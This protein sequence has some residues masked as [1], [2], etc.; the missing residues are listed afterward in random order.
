MGVITSFVRGLSSPTSFPGAQAG[1]QRL[2]RADR[3]FRQAPRPLSLRQDRSIAQ[4]PP[5]P[6]W[7]GYATPRLLSTS[8][9]FGPPSIV[10]CPAPFARK[11]MSALP[12]PHLGQSGNREP[13]RAPEPDRQKQRHDEHCSWVEPC[14]HIAWHSIWVK[15]PRM[16]AGR[17]QRSGTIMALH[18]RS[19]AGPVRSSLGKRVPQTRNAQLGVNRVT[20]ANRAG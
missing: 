3:S 10:L 18:C 13:N 5:A 9:A 2:G 6:P 19:R 20:S 16:D 17:K 4:L 12:R 11:I 1:L 8:T 14:D 15:S 7:C